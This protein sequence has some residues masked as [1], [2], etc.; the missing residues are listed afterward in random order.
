MTINQILLYDNYL[1]FCSIY[2]PHLQ[3]PKQDLISNS[4]PHLIQ[5]IRSFYVLRLR[6][7]FTIYPFFLPHGLVFRPGLPISIPPL[8]QP[9]ILF[10]LS[11]WL[12]LILQEKATRWV[13]PANDPPNQTLHARDISICPP[14]PGQ[15][16]FSRHHAADHRRGSGQ[17]FQTIWH[18][19]AKGLDGFIRRVRH[20]KGRTLFDE[21]FWGQRQRRRGRDPEHDE[22]R[23]D[24]HLN[25]GARWRCAKACLETTNME[26]MDAC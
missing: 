21:R 15:S 19:S 13:C 26:S 18:S 23:S 3:N 20:S 5:S 17:D 2:F 16:L 4:L 11:P 24:V 1:E 10:L 22:D 9:P 6:L 25:A 12:I 8:L 14:T 7:G